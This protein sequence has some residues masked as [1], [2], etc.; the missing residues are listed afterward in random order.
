MPYYTNKYIKFTALFGVVP[1]VC[2]R[3]AFMNYFCKFHFQLLSF[4]SLQVCCC[5][6]C[7]R[8][9]A[10]AGACHAAM[11]PAR[12]RHGKLGQKLRCCHETATDL[13]KDTHT[14]RHTHTDKYIYKIIYIY[15]CV[16]MF[17]FLFFNIYI[18]IYTQYIII[19]IYIHINM[20]VRN[21]KDRQR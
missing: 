17:L 12:R 7:Q 4:S 1:P 8:F 3:A 16:C 6:W 21:Y 10:G 2:S 20:E 5:C 19:Y 13:V 18:Y 9:W 11:L 15:V 14:H